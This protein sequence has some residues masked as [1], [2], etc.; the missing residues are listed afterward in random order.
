MQTCP[1]AGVGESYWWTWSAIAISGLGV[2]AYHPAAAK[3][4]RAAAGPSAQGMSWFALGG[5]VGIAL[6]P[7][8]VTPVLLAFGI[9]GT[10]IL[11]LPAV[12][13]ALFLYCIRSRRAPT[14]SRSTTAASNHEDTTSA[15]DQW[16]LFGWLTVLV[17]IRSVM[18]FGVTTVLVLYVISRFAVTQSAGS[19]TLTV[20]LAV[21]ALGT[22]VGGWSADRLSRLFAIRLG[23]ALCLPSLIMLLAAPSMVVAVTAVA[24]L[25]LGLY[26]PFSVQTTLGQDYL[27]N[28]IGTA[29]GVTLGLAVSAG[30]ACAP[31]FGWLGDQ[32]GLTWSLGVLLIFPLLAFLVSFRLKDTNPR[33]S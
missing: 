13:M 22:L 21:G 9:A 24:L 3:A 17:V 5:N 20:F 16:R 2:A 25:G 15:P 12:A 7:V 4:A 14:L 11:A 27:P 29:S 10:P 32:Y 33:L 28:R 23:Y 19:L 31:L 1:L 26:L 30:G 8:I 18:Y 6:G